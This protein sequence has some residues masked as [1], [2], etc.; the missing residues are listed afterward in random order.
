MDA[1]L[2]DAPAKR[3]AIRAALSWP[4]PRGAEK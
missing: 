3:V 4:L 1:V 2:V